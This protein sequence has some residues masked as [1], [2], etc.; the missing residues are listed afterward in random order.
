MI[1]VRLGDKVRDRV[2]GY[3]GIATSRT[4]FLNGCI[5]IEGGNGSSVCSNCGNNIC[6]EWEN[7][8][9][10]PD[11]CNIKNEKK[12][13]SPNYPTEIKDEYP[14]YTISQMH[15]LNTTGIFNTEG[16]LVYLSYCPPCPKDAECTICESPNI[17]ISEK[18][19]FTKCKETELVVD[20]LVP[21]LDPN[22]YNKFEL[23]KK[24]KFTL[25]IIKPQEIE[26]YF[27]SDSCPKPKIIGKII[28][29]EKTE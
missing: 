5:Q 24:F 12:Y 25:E 8:C 1:E 16:Y 13:S 27:I 7:P 17:V 21:D 28:G 22:I 26:Y 19:N 3:S 29:I 14:F 20:I 9:N 10:C 4:E 6:E 18:N 2:T 11:D 23:D 15:D